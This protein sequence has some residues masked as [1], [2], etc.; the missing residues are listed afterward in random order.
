MDFLGFI[1]LVAIAWWLKS[2]IGDVR[3]R[4][5]A[6]ELGLSDLRRQIDELHRLTGTAPGTSSPPP[7]PTP[8]AAPA[9]TPQDSPGAPPSS[10]PAV[11]DTS[12]RSP[13][14]T[15]AASAAP[16][17]DTAPGSDGPG[18]EERLGTRWAVWVGALALALG[19]LLLVRYSI[20]NNLIGP[21]LRLFFG[22]MLALGLAFAGEHMRRRERA[23]NLP[24]LPAAHIPS[25]LTS[26]ATAVALGTT[27]AAHAVY[28]FLD[29]A[30]A[31]VLLG[32]I[33]L[34]AL[35]GAA[36]HGPALAGVGLLAS[37]VVPLLVASD[38]P[39]PWPVVLYLGIV[40]GAAY[41]LS[42][43]RAW[44]WLA[45]GVVAGAA[46]WGFVLLIA[47]S[48]PSA[49]SLTA[50]MTHVLLQLAL[51]TFF[52]C[53]EPHVG[54]A[55]TDAA[56]D[57][58]GMTALLVLFA[59][60][61]G[62]VVIDHSESS[63]SVAFALIAIGTLA[64]TG[65]MIAPV[66]AA[67]VLSGALA[68]TVLADW[69]GVVVA[70]EALPAY[71]RE[72]QAALQLPAGI[73]SF[74]TFAIT[75]PLAIFATAML[76]LWR[77]AMLPAPT[78]AFYA[79]AATLT[80]LAAFVV[81]YLR[82]TQF[83]HSLRFAASAA[84]LA[85]IFAI[86][87][88]M[89]WRAETRERTPANSLA[90]GALSAAAIAA[91]A[92]ALTCSLERGYLTVAFAIA[93]LG[94]AFVAVRRDVPLLRF[95][96]VALGTVVLVRVF[97]DPRIM[98]A[99]VGRWP[100]LNWLLF[101]YGVPAACFA[102]AARLLRTRTDDV[103]VRLCDGLAVLFAALLVGYQI[104]HLLY[105]GDPL[106]SATGHVELGL[107]TTASL[108]FAFVL[109][110]LDLARANPVFRFASIVFGVLAALSALIGL[111][112]AENPLFDRQIVAGRPW[113]SSLAL[114]Y[115]LPGLTAVIAARAARETRPAWYV[116][117]LAALAVLLLLAF[118]SL[119][120]RHTFQGALVMYWR[121]TSGAEHWAYSAAWLLLGIAF[122]AY[123]ALLR[124]KPARLASAGLVLLAVL[125]V[126]LFDLQGLTGLWRALS[127]I[128]LGLVLIGIGLVYQRL[129][130]QPRR[131]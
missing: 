20:E 124:S 130:F 103:S 64:A 66:A 89:F 91:L 10:V 52:I 26:A 17:P 82:V 33:S 14:I 115:L 126:F 5:A 43:L 12:W 122:L 83:D 120:V 11:N 54:R 84:V 27:Y 29:P 7:T 69:R 129:L 104:R 45:A 51:A 80:P 40:A 56:P 60:A 106:S 24:I 100:V 63:R 119:E 96:V 97:M 87:A 110:R 16:L 109:A 28:G 98:G 112:L 19:G 74:L 32:A 58:V 44:L 117:M 34:A 116:N 131:T 93:A 37:F 108:A 99:D 70:P 101:G 6:S 114:G 21:G 2:A 94:A 86:A 55:D 25:A 125:K 50:G 107:Q 81:A 75:V 102:L 79:A 128:T 30:A 123:G 35:A 3:R 31:F 49:V 77:G 53:I 67:T 76:R 38:Q 4:L 113:L 72:F 78:A 22:G 9:A 59:L 41:A 68:V 48:Q 57:P 121:P 61:V 47:A 85:A 105:A 127:F 1:I 42:R 18:L 92:F 46:A 118:V 15:N 36:L 73:R 13:P 71:L 90:T 23:L 88:E 62:A 95:A 8:E 111:G 39:N 65:F